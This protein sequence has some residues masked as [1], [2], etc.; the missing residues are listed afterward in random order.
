MKKVLFLAG[1][2]GLLL[3]GCTPAPLTKADYD[4]LVVCHPDVLDQVE[5]AAR[6]TFAQVY[7]YNCPKATLRVI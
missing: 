7:W 3:A 4:G 2:A 5:R 6:R 1:V